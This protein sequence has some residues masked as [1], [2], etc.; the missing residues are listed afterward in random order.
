[1][2]RQLVLVVTLALALAT[3]A[4]AQGWVKLFDGK[5]LKA[6]SVHS[7]TATYKAENKMIVGT[8]VLGS[9]NSFLCTEKEFGDFILEFEVKVDPE[10]NSGV[11]IRSEIAREE[12]VWKATRNG[13]EITRK[14]PPDRVYGYQ[15]EI[16]T[17][18]TGNSGNIYDEARRA[19]FLDDWKNKP[20][21]RAAFK[22]GQWNKYRVECR[23]DSIKT[24]VNGI[25]CADIKDS[26]TARGIIG[27]QVHAIPK[28][29]FKPYQAR[30]RN[31]RIK[32]LK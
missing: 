21:A 3:G 7:G 2:T 13:K 16:A 19:M 26:M 20:Q 8:A 5:T 31:I 14:A 29:K 15:V 30:W 18:A 22:D 10:L 17:A 27:L 28:D 6:W 11:Q 32:E 24:W 12:K 4:S 1:M 25:A 9:Q 23:G